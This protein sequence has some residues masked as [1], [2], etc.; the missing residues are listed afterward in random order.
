[1][2]LTR[3]ACAVAFGL[4]CHSAFAATAY[5]SNEKDDS[6]SVIDLDSLEVTAT[7]AV[8]MRPRGLLLSSDTQQPPTEV[9]G[10]VTY[11]LKVRIRVD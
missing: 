7:L 3:L 5:V 2:R 1:M 9:G 11:G 10:L 8:G 6:I 4:A